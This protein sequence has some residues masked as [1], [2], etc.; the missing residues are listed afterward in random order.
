MKHKLYD[1]KKKNILEVY[2]KLI[3]EKGFENISTAK[4]A[5]KAQISSALIY[6]YFENK[7]TLIYELADSIFNECQAESMPLVDKKNTGYR[8]E[9]AKYI[10]Q[11]LSSESH[12]DLRLFTAFQYLALKDDV[13]QK[14]FFEH[15][16]YCVSDAFDTLKY[17]A[18]KGVIAVDSLAVAA[19]YMVYIIGSVQN[20]RD[21]QESAEDVTDI[22]AIL[23]SQLYQYFNFQECL[24]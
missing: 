6:H 23:R 12:I 15:N 22:L 2:G 1:T 13:I 3:A 17:F 20:L 16:T 5:R 11:I 10:E 9:F 7:Q 14:K 24:P 8:E 4:L 19:K 18:E 21:S